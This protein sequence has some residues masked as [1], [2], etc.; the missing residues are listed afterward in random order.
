MCVF[1]C[2]CVCVCMCKCVCARERD[3]E[4]ERERN[5][6]RERDIFLK[7]VF[8]KLRFIKYM[9]GIMLKEVLFFFCCCCCHC[10]FFFFFFI[11]LDYVKY[12]YYL[13]SSNFYNRSTRKIKRKE[14]LQQ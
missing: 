13:S 6:E 10:V 4:R 3:R 14:E 12:N 8:R 5:R 9:G 2:V 7:V 1:V 11:F